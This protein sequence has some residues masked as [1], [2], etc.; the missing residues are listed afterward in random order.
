MTLV[1][2]A[3]EVAK[4][5][6]A[7]SRVGGLPWV[8]E[9]RGEPGIG[10]TRL[11]D[12]LRAKAEAQGLRVMTG[13]ATEQGRATPFSPLI[14]ALT[15]HVGL[16]DLSRAQREALTPVCP[17]NHPDVQVDNYRVRRAIRALLQNLA[18]PAGLVLVLE[19][20]HWADDPT[21]NLVTHLLRHPPAAPVLLVLSYRPAQVPA[22]VTA[23]LAASDVETIE[24][25]PLSVGDFAELLGPETSRAR[26]EDLH[27]D[28]GGNPFYLKLLTQ[29]GANDL[30]DEIIA[31]PPV[32]RHVAR[33]AS[34]AGVEFEPGLVSAITAGVSTRDALQALDDLQARDLIRVDTDERRL[35][36]RHR[37]VR[38]AAYQD[39]DDEWRADAHHCVAAEL[40]K[41]DAP[42]IVRAP[43]IAL[44][45]KQG[46]VDAVQTLLRAASA[47]MPEDPGT[48]AG[49]LRAALALVPARLPGL[50]L[51]ALTAAGRALAITG[52]LPESRDLLREAMAHI[53]PDDVDTR[54]AVAV[55]YA[56]VTRLLGFYADA[57][58]TLHHELATLP[59][60]TD[61]T[62]LKLE[63]LLVNVVGGQLDSDTD[64][65]DEVLAAARRS[66][67]RLLEACGHAVT[68]WAR[69]FVGDL[70]RAAASCD[71]A[72]TLLDGL[73]DGEI[74][75]WVE[76]MLWLSQAE[77][78]L[79]RFDDALRHAD[80]GVALAKATGRN[81]VLTSLLSHRAILLRLL[82]R[83]AEA[84]Q[85]AQDGVDVAERINSQAR[86]GV[87][88]QVWS[89]IRLIAGDPA[90]AV[91]LATLAMD[92]AGED[93]D[94]WQRN[95]RKSLL[96]ATT[97]LDRVDR[98][99]EVLDVLGG[100]DLTRMQPADRPLHYAELVTADLTCGNIDRAA[101][102]ASLAERYADSRLPTRTGIA[103]LAWAQV[104]FARG[105]YAAAWARARSAV[106]DFERRGA[107]FDAGRA[108]LVWGLATA[109]HGNSAVAIIHL[110]QARILFTASD[111]PNLAARATRELRQLG[112][113][114]AGSDTLT[115]RE[116]EIADL[117]ASGATNRQ[118]AA[119]LVISERTVGTHLSR[120]YAKLGVSSR[121]ALA[122]QR[123]RDVEG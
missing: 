34:V 61:T 108:H 95:L 116:L 19:D 37:L 112:R 63:L 72:K 38:E 71:T 79:D 123:T 122:A 52:E 49:W 119:K 16:A 110:E 4:L 70:D 43:H 23:V 27:R 76:P 5:E 36:F 42:A 54:V 8:L 109:A 2:R 45:A 106:A 32:T 104:L 115:A 21:I 51:Q 111:A 83:L 98:T 66:K 82:G 28:S 31:L 15:G 6:A 46:D 26:V 87:A 80:R 84:T 91:R 86:R 67:D 114:A 65:T 44:S 118:I 101:E 11:I 94:F 50:R 20:L 29:E 55:Q 74:A 97:E 78:Y 9:I 33:A 100:P 75:D 17:K 10:K 117:V 3:A 30:Y 90:D 96:L 12:E 41:R 121:A 24:L 56:T 73:P 14:E 22:K 58:A 35:R 60:N 40:A 57:R 13:R 48:A 85:S 103:H 39:G 47:L 7:V 107:W 68:A 92:T 93:P 53:P 25:M 120:I 99:A 102:W 105:D 62:R 77:R 88:L 18:K 64:L 81:Y 113:R 1:G 69:Y 89:R 59:P